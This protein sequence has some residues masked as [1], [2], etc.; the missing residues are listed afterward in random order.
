MFHVKSV[1]LSEQTAV[2]ELMQPSTYTVTWK[3]EGNP[4]LKDVP[5][6]HQIWHCEPTVI[7]FEGHRYMKLSCLNEQ[8]EDLG[9]FLVNKQTFTRETK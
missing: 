3:Y 2:L 9:N 8:G 4:A 6:E 1:N 5:A 7:D